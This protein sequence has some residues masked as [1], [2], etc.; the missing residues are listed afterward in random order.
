MFTLQI[1]L[2][3]V[4]SAQSKYRVVKIMRSSSKVVLQTT[5]HIVIYPSSGS[6]L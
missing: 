3:L 1:I 6:F 5:K 2:V 4:F